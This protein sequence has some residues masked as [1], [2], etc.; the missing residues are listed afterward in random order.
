MNSKIK[1]KDTALVLYGHSYGFFSHGIYT[2]HEI[3]KDYNVVL[4]VEESYKNN[5]KFKELLNIMNFHEVVYYVSDK[6]NP[7]II[8]GFFNR[9]NIFRSFK[10]QYN[11]SKLVKN[12]LNNYDAKLLVQHDYIDIENMYFFH[13]AKVFNPSILKISILSMSPSNKLTQLGF[14]DNRLKRSLKL[15]RNFKILGYSIY[16]LL[17]LKKAVES[18]INNMIIPLFLIGRMP[19]FGISTTDNV[20]IKPKENLFDYHLVYE[21]FESF[22]YTGLLGNKSKIS[23]VQ[24]PITSSG[25]IN[26]K[27]F[28]LTEDKGISIF[29][30]LTGLA[31]YEQDLLD[32]WI[33][34]INILKRRHPSSH[35]SIKFHPFYSDDLFKTTKDYIDSKCN[36]ISFLRHGYSI[37]AEEIILNSWLVIGDVSSILPWAMYCPN[38]TVLSM[39]IETDLNSR[40]MDH[41]NNIIVFSKNSDF[42]E[43]LNQIES[44][45]KMI[46]NQINIPT[47][48]DFISKLL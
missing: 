4:I 41:F 19:Y 10:K 21:E 40:D 25:E 29:F 27:I 20:D 3:A 6:Y 17:S 31:G 11:F 47:L 38:K 8:E 32:R 36:E 12:I 28:S 30:S 42:E 9:L 5:K 37:S 48:T 13:Y 14:L 33:L 16:Y 24:S 7:E 2:C 18:L 23:R 22:F 34:L 43:S 26:K 35:I 39:D 15:A 46:N 1:I 44:R 45:N